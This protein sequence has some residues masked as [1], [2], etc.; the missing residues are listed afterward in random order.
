MIPIFII[1]YMGAGKTTFGKALARKLGKGFIDLDFYIT[2]RFRKSVPQLFEERGEEGFRLLENSMLRE[3]GEFSDVVVA[4]G[5]GT[6]CFGNNMDYMNER[7]LTVLLEADEECLVRR[8]LAGGARRPL[9]AGKSEPDLRAFIRTHLSERA[10]FYGKA[11]TV[12]GGSRLENRKEIEETVDLFLQTNG[13]YLN[14][15][16]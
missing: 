16:P 3:V 10:P 14:F 2:Q 4:C 13:K 6:P 9:V 11:T 5:G 15:A 12:V 1:G 8:L 7:G